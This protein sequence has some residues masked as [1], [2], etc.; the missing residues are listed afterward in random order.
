MEFMIAIGKE[1]SKLQLNHGL[2]MAIDPIK[3][4]RVTSTFEQAQL[5]N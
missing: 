5:I 2:F 1:V 4:N 3:R